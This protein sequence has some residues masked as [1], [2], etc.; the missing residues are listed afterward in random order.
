[1]SA[2]TDER[3]AELLD[4]LLSTESHHF[5]YLQVGWNFFMPIFNKLPFSLH[6]QVDKYK[7]WLFQ[8]LE[9]IIKIVMFEVENLHSNTRVN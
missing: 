8:K 5:Q 2:Q 4:C 7:I 6:S 3:A 1:M 9:K